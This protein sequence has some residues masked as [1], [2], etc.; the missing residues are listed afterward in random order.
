MAKKDKKAKKM[1]TQTEEQKEIFARA[2]E[3]LKHCIE[4]TSTIREEILDDLK[5]ANGKHWSDDM[6]KQ[7]KGRPCLTIDRLS[8]Q[9]NQVCNEHRQ[10]RA[11]IKVRPFD[12]GPDPAKAENTNGL[13][14]HITY[15]SNTTHAID[16]AFDHAVQGGAGFFRVLTKY[17]D[18]TGFEQEIKIAGVKNPLSVYFPLDIINEPDYSDAPYAFIRER[19]SKRQFELDY[20]DINITSFELSGT[21]DTKTWLEKDSVYICEYFEVVK[22]NQRTIYLLS[23]GKILEDKDTIVAPGVTVASERETY[24]TKIMWHKLCGA[25]I[26]ESREWPSKYIPIIPIL[27]KEVN[28]DGELSLRSVTRN[29]KDPQRNINYWK[30]C[31]TEMIALAPKVPYVMAEG[32]ADGHDEWKDCNNKNY[33]HLTYSPVTI[34]GQLAPPPQ[35]VG[36]IGID[37]GI[38]NAIRESVDDLMAATGVYPATLGAPSNESSGR[39]IGMRKSQGATANY[40][41]IDSAELATTYL[42]KIL[43]DLIPKIFDTKRIIRILGD[44]MQEKTVEITDG[45]FNDIE[46]WDIISDVGPDYKTSR[47]ELVQMLASLAQSAPIF[48]EIGAPAMAR[49]LDAKGMDAIADIM[50]KVINKKYGET[51]FI[52]K[53]DPNGAPTPQEMA[54]IVAD[55]QGVQQQLQAAGQENE[56]L[57]QIIGQ[58]QAQIKDKDA[59]RQTKI[60]TE[61]IKSQT[62]IEKAKITVEPQIMANMMAAIE[63]IRSKVDTLEK[64]ASP[65]LAQ[66]AGNK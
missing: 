63:H 32:Q 43:I 20:P 13:I 40:H 50:E 34:G 19:I 1:L 55:L 36:N 3:N 41:F 60:I 2:E 14:R 29:A 33:S 61:D 11:S 23:D 38:V 53:N 5:F 51:L 22:E 48:G 52:D 7:R 4:V 9:L 64:G 58:L 26:L 39:A 54:A 31:E 28:I 25:G 45:Y 6:L 16:Q 21:G 42:G 30:S 15:N 66:S 44:D 65:A 10:N 62:A 17:R 18:D 56:Q 46:G 37:T 27:G 35:R 8:L 47:V 24:D 12:S 49:N 59:D 57:K